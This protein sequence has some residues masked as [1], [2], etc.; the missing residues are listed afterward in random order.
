MTAFTELMRGK[1]RPN[2]DIKYEQ[3]VVRKIT[4]LIIHTDTLTVLV[5]AAV[6]AAFAIVSVTVPATLPA[7]AAFGA[8][9]AASATALGTAAATVFLPKRP[10]STI[11]LVAAL[12]RLDVQLGCAQYRF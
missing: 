3:I 8:A 6:A 5:A 2:S 12:P 10:S 9:F 4:N 7:A 1:K 11:A